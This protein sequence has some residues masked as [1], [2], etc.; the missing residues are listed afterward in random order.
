MRP[1]RLVY[2]VDE[3]EKEITLIAFGHRKEIYRLMM[4]LEE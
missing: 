4:F 2:K 3:E 1:Y